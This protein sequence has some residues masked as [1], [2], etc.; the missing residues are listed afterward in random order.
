[1]FELIMGIREVSVS[2]EPVSEDKVV[3]INGQRAIVV[4]E[5]SSCSS[6]TC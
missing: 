6:G 5:K 4:K 2:L 1:M 3:S